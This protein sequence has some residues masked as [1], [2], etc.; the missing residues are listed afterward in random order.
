LA[1]AELGAPLAPVP[2]A[3]LVELHAVAASVSA[4][5]T[6]VTVLARFG[7]TETTLS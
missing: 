6:A 1:A 2:P 4:A 5:S 7:I 3:G